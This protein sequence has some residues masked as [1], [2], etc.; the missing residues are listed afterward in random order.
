VL[1]FSIGS[2]PTDRTNLP[3]AKGI[4]GSLKHQ[5]SWPL[6]QVL[7]ILK[8]IDNEDVTIHFSDMGAMKIDIDSGIGRYSY[9]LPAS[10][11]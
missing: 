11:A 9:I 3:F 2:G 6:S 5:W 7:S 4:T 8:L 10:K 1:N